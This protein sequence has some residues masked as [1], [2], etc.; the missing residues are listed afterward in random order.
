MIAASHVNTKELSS[1]QIDS[2]DYSSK[3]FYLK[4]LCNKYF[5]HYAWLLL[6]IANDGFNGKSV[7]Q[8]YQFLFINYSLQ[9]GI[10]PLSH[11]ATLQ[12]RSKYIIA[13]P[14]EQ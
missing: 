3:G 2:I 4:K 5:L 1:P 8:R 9:S 11:D 12:I 10:E 6:L 13:V 7:R 14:E